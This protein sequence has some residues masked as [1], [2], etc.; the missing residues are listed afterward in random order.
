MKIHDILSP[1]Y[2]LH[3]TPDVF[4]FTLGNNNFDLFLQYNFC[5]ICTKLNIVKMKLVDYFFRSG[6][7]KWI[8]LYILVM[9]IISLLLASF[10]PQSI[11]DN[12][13]DSLDSTLS[14]SNKKNIKKASIQ[15][16]KNHN[17]KP[18]KSD[19]KIKKD[20][21]DPS[22]KYIKE[23]KEKYQA[24]IFN[25][26]HY[27]YTIDYQ[28]NLKNKNAIFYIVVDDVFQENGR[29]FIKAAKSYLGL[30]VYLKFQCDRLLTKKLKDTQYYTYVV[31]K[32]NSINSIYFNS[33]SVSP[34]KVDI[35]LA[36]NSK[37]LII[38]GKCLDMF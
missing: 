36:S 1:K 23:Y 34:D 14:I 9:S 3:F 31:A 7:A 38:T 6:P 19:P 5:I 30:N 37:N 15:V 27:S 29:T 22:V 17:K 32:I 26:V 8:I 25:D 2:L 18:G 20:T 33:K 10:R 24:V 28:E 35:N 4:S 11:T 21:L 16:L 13:D 12:I